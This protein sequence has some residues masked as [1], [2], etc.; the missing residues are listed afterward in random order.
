[1]N[2]MN[3]ESNAPRGTIVIGGSGAL[4]REVVRAIHAE[5]G[6]VGL[7]YF[8]NADG[9]NEL[10]AELPGTVAAFAD[11]RDLDS[12]AAAIDELSD[13][14]PG[15][16]S[17]VH[18]A[19]ICLAPGDPVPDH[20]AQKMADISGQGW[21]ELMALNVKSVFFSCQQ[22][23]PK[24]QASGGGNLVLVGSISGTRPLP[25]PI[26]YATSKMALEGMARSM[27]KEFGGDNLRVNVVEPGIL[28]DGLSRTLPEALV[29]EYK[30]HCALRRVGQ[31]SEVASVIAWLAVANT[32]VSGQAILVDGAL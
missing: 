20:S 1:M 10:C 19:S 14:L 29:D 25:S 24:M 22:V 26:H 28:E 9:A 8:Q 27:A 12:L 7:T 18:C 3:V 23:I 16:T 15:V 21:D 6:K 5:G 2:A 32:Y 30:K 11:G 13:R 17:L 31:M 4:G